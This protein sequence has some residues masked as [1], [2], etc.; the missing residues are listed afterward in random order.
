MCVVFAETEIVGLLASGVLPEDILA[1]VETAIATRI[2]SMAGGAGRAGALYR[3]RGPGA[4]HGYGSQRGARPSG[5]D[6]PAAAVYLRP[7]AALLAAHRAGELPP[8]RT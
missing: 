8:G 6:R 3:G 7:G 2:A 4:G 1:G 5:A